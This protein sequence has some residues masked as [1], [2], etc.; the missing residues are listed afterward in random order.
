LER[1]RLGRTSFLASIISLGTVEIGMP[2]G[3]AAE[4]RRGKSAKR[5]P[6]ACCMAHWTGGINFID[7]PRLYGESEAIIGR[8][9]AGRGNEYFLATKTPLFENALDRRKSI[10]ASVEESLRQL[11]TEVI[12]LLQLHSA[13]VE[14]LASVELAD[15]LDELRQPSLVRFTGASVYREE[16]A[17]VEIR[18]GRFDYPQ[19]AWNAADRRPE[20]AVLPAA[21]ENDVGVVVCSVLLQGALTQHSRSLPA[22][23]QAAAEY[24]QRGPLPAKAV[25]LVRAVSLEPEEMLN[26]AAW[27]MG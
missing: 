6:R 17:L 3:L 20:A 14:A 19:I 7:T 22:E 5:K 16:P 25:A 8:T 1:R 26:P 27:G 4:A 18:F 12:D 2:Y 9:L 13:G 23:V 15:V 10:T 11:R 24:V 21:R